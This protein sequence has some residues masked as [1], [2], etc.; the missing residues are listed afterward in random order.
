MSSLFK[1]LI[2]LAITLAF[3]SYLFLDKTLAAYF[4]TNPQSI[5]IIFSY[6]TTLGLSQYYLIPSFLLF[7]IFIKKNNAISKAS[8]FIFLSVSISGI[9]SIVIKMIFA[10]YR[11]YMLFGGDH[12]YGFSWFDYGYLVNSFPSGHTTTAFSAFVGFCF[13]FPR[14]KILFLLLATLIA[15]SRVVLDVH[16]LSDVIMGALLGTLTTYFL[17]IK[18]YKENM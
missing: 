14:Y 16:Y 1:F 13:L 3:L 9:L 2:V 7:L 5:E 12:L 6:I 18:L 10:R 15:F 11:P 17:Y 8:L 4:S